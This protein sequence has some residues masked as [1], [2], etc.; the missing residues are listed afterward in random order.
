VLNEADEAEVEMKR[1][2][3]GGQVCAI[4]ISDGPS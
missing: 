2:E 1:V 4:D 3:E